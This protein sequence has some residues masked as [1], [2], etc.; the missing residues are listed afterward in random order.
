MPHGA[1]LSWPLDIL[2]WTL[3]HR[4][5]AGWGVLTVPPASLV[6][7]PPVAEAPSH[8]LGCHASS[9]VSRVPCEA[10]PELGSHGGL[11]TGQDPALCRWN[12]SL[13]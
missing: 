12:P 11:P 8:L 9:W 1:A 2:L 4:Q 10:P 3:A 6:P 5:G 7:F 13:Q